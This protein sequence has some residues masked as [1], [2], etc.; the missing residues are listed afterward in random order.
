[1]SYVA[2]FLGDKPVLS[3]VP[4][5]LGPRWV[6]P[7][8]WLTI[9]AIGPT[10]QK[11][12]GLM[13]VSNDEANFVALVATASSGTCTIDWGDGTV[14]VIAS[15]TR[16]EHLYNFANAAL[17]AVKADGLKQA[18][19]TITATT[20]NLTGI[21]LQKRYFQ[22][23]GEPFYGQS[24]KWLDISIS[25]PNLTSMIIG[26]TTVLLTY[27]RKATIGRFAVTSL[28]SL[29]NGC[30]S[31]SEITPFVE[32]V[33]AV[34]SM[35]SMFSN[36]MS[37]RTIPPF[38]GS[39]A[40]VNNMLAMFNGCASLLTIPAFPGSVA[41]VTNM[42]TM[43]QNCSSLQSI[44]PF[45]GSVAA[46]TLMTSMF[47]G[48]ASLLTIPAFPGSVAAVTNMS[49]MFQGCVSLQ[50][51]P[52]FPV[53]VAAVTT[54]ASMFN[55]CSSLQTTPAFPGSVAAVTTMNGM[56]NSCLSLRTIPA[57]PSITAAVTNMS[58]MFNS[59]STLRSIPAIQ[60]GGITSNANINFMFANCTSL[61]VGATSGIRY[62]INYDACLLSASQ[63]NAIYTGLGAAVAG[64]V[65]TVSSNFG[66]AASNT[67][68]ATAKGWILA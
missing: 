9:P 30:R 63:L 18:R 5:N 51:I 11:F 7:A 6:R 36:C 27:L 21:D 15:G 8:D 52:P 57:F 48:C 31:L 43:F 2:A 38:P 22:P 13:G 61:V 59:C 54:M 32:S 39:V 53:S 49:S 62:T 37:L 33:S 26:G 3:L 24:V 42:A 41:A 64:S 44:P 25:S 1:M 50:I 40:A 60:T 10:E 55:N 58:S 29:F 20:G 12:I 45:P 17:G 19:V 47:N 56:F 23:S 28:A 46:V 4:E 16:A 67:G 66:Y 34:T 14:E 68:I 35:A 65:L